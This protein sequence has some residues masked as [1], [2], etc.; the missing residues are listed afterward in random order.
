VA[1]AEPSV[2]TA[3][4]GRGFGSNR[5]RFALAAALVLGACAAWATL[6]RPARAPG[7]VRKQLHADM[8]AGR[9]ARCAESLAWL[10]R[11]DRWTSEDRMVQ[12]WVAKGLGRPDDGL[13]ALSGIDSDDPLAPRA[14]L[15]AA[16]IEFQRDRAR[17]AEASLLAALRIDPAFAPVRHELVRLYSRQQRLAA[18]NEQFRALARQGA[19]DFTHLHFWCLTR[20]ANWNAA[21]DVEALGRSVRADVDDAASR[22]ALADGLRRL[23]RLDE[24]GALVAS[25]P[26]TDPDARVLRV[27]LALDRGDPDGAQRLAGG[28]PDNHAALAQLRGQLALVRGDGPAAVRHLRTAH[29]LEPDDRQTLFALASALRIVGEPTAARPFAAAVRR[30]DALRAVAAK[31]ENPSAA[32]DGDLLRAVGA[33]SEA[34]GRRSEARAW[35]LL[36]VRCNPLD[37]QAQQ[38]L[39]RLGD[40]PTDVSPVGVDGTV[41]D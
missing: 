12:A 7:L 3:A 27:R 9:L 6:G 25:L 34:V 11:H 38:S 35:Y 31:L 19:L 36:A 40:A 37:A 22:R 20:N 16:L 30:Y 33:A 28:G 5:T 4:A 41:A 23:G 15:T 18:L 21:A 17:S 32:T 10:A 29:R 26:E 39:Y 1:R 13:A 14:L 2:E 24:A 8:R